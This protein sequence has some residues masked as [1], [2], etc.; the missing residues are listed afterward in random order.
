MKVRIDQTFRKDLNK[1][2]DKQLE[3]KV[4]NIIEA[5]LKANKLSEV[6][7]LKKLQGSDKYFRIRC[8]DYRMG[9]I[10]ENEEC[11]IVRILHR[12]EIYRF[13]P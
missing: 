9:L 7:N 13:F 10:F 5:I 12:K 8:G 11:I 6:K 2:K 3:K 4:A 1:L